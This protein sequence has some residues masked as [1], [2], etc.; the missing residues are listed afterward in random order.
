MT[1]ILQA[2]VACATL[3]EQPAVLTPLAGYTRESIGGVEVLWNPAFDSDRSLRAQ[4]RDAL[5]A[6]LGALAPDVADE[7]AGRRI[8]VSP[9]S[10]AMVDLPSH[11]HG[12][13]WHRSARWLVEHHL[14]AER[15]G[16][17]E[18]YD[19]SDYLARRA[20]DP[21]ILAR[22]LRESAGLP[23]LTTPVPLDHYRAERIGNFEVLW[24]PAIDADTKR[25]RRARAALLADIETVQRVAPAEALAV[26]DGTRIAVTTATLGADGAERHGLE[27]HRSADWLVT[28][29]FDAAREGAVEVSNVDDYLAWRAEQPMCVLHELTHV[30]EQKADAPTLATLQSAFAEAVSSSRYN[31]VGYVL[32]APGETRRAYALSN[33]DEYGA[34]LAEALFGRNDYAPFIRADLVE[35][36]PAGCRAVAG[37]WRTTC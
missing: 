30:L 35:F 1:I 10:P 33:A 22:S 34:E 12:L 21:G 18:V 14:D 17:V 27:T 16:V 5:S 20:S 7:V 37:L 28:H 25:Q 4:T 15:Q 6:D 19:A 24:S 26:L 11:G 9:S 36:D 8:A 23:A 32:A 29:R 13:G 31:A 3:A 2:L